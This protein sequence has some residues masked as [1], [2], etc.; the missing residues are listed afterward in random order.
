MKAC[1]PLRGA[2]EFLHAFRVDSLPP[3]ADRAEKSFLGLR[4]CAHEG[5]FFVDAFR[6]RDCVACA[7]FCC[8]AQLSFFEVAIVLLHPGDRPGAEAF[9]VCEE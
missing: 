2:H 9:V 1:A 4:E 3:E 5:E 8:A 7:E 6:H